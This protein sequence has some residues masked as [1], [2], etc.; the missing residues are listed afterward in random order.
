MIQYGQDFEGVMKKEKDNF[1][2][3]PRLSPNH[4]VCAFLRRCLRQMKKLGLNQTDLARR[5]NVSR[6]YLTKLMRADVNISF[7]TALRL[8][9]ALEMDFVPELR[10]RN[11]KPRP[12][13]LVLEE[14]KELPIA[15]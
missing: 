2:V 6:P 7:G 3:S 5:L 15:K 11:P 10:E 13:T 9:R 1:K 14:D 12:I 4:L 8:A